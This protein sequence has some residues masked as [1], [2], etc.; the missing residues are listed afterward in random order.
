[1]NIQSDST[2]ILPEM[3]DLFQIIHMSQR[4][5]PKLERYTLW[6]RIE[7]LLIENIELI[8]KIKF[9]TVTENKLN[10]LSKLSCNTDVL[11]IL[12]RIAYDTKC[13]QQ[14]KYVV[15]EEKLVI[16]GKMIGGWMKYIQPRKEI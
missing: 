1:M 12:L 11:K 5:L 13:L 16:I 4:N 6:K 15:I 9:H 2:S 7:D 3:T 8:I 14:K 10:I